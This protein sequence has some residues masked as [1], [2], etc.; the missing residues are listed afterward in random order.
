GRTGRLALP[1][2][3]LPARREGGARGPRDPGLSSGGRGPREGLRFGG[4]RHGRARGAPRRGHLDPFANRSGAPRPQGRAPRGPS[5]P[6]RNRGARRRPSPRALLRARGTPDSSRLTGGAGSHAVV[7]YRVGSEPI[8]ASPLSWT[9]A[10]PRRRSQL[11]APH[12]QWAFFDP[13]SSVLLIRAPPFPRGGSCA[14][15]SRGPPALAGR[16]RPY[17]PHPLRNRVPMA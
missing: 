4:Q 14:D 6:R 11:R 3:P 1:G 2:P 16:P 15:S 10:S 17:D 7:P 5:G 13:G 9:G 12:S 8:R